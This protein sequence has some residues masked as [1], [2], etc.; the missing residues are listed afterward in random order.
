MPTSAEAKACQ[1]H[2]SKWHWAAASCQPVVILRVE[3]VCC[4]AHPRPSTAV[5]T[6]L[7][8]TVLWGSGCPRIAEQES[9]PLGWVTESVLSLVLTSVPPLGKAAC[10]SFTQ[11]EHLSW[12]SAFFKATSPLDLLLSGTEGG[13]KWLATHREQ[14][15]G[16]K[17]RCAWGPIPEA[18]WKTVWRAEKSP[19]EGLVHTSNNRVPVFRD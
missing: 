3:G 7:S 1:L 9:L 13:Q 4:T 6:R 11:T 18:L 8:H 14:H 16:R 10:S 19:S 17:R 15:Q 12:K 2:Y 5:Q